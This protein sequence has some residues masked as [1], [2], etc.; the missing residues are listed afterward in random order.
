[1]LFYKNDMES[2]MNSDYYSIMVVWV[3]IEAS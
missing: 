3:Q 1:M 2:Y